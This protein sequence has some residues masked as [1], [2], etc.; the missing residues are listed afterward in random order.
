[1]LVLN[2]VGLEKVKRFQEDRIR[3]VK[4]AVIQEVP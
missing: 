1:M 2:R 3:L 4:M